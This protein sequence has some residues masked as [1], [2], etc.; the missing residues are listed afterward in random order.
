MRNVTFLKMR[1]SEIRVKRIRVNQ[2]LGVYK[3]RQLSLERE[4]IFST[5]FG[6]IIF[7]NASLC[8]V[9]QKSGHTIAF[10]AC[11]RNLWHLPLIP[12]A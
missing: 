1:V 2:G 11:L 12:F 5:Y 3:L 7:E 6:P 4:E 9:L 8:T 10:A